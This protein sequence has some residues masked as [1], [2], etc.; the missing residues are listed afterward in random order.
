MEDILNGR[1][2]AV[3]Q[4]DALSSLQG[5]PD[6]S[7][8][9]CVTSP[10]YFG[11]RWYGTAPVRWPGMA[12]A[13]IAGLPPVDVPEW[14]GELGLEPD[15]MWFVGHLVLIFREIRRVLRKD[16]T[17]WLNLGDSA[18]SHGAGATSKELRWMGDAAASREARTPPDGLKPKNMVGIPWRVA[19]ALQADG[20]HLRCDIIYAKT[21]PMPESVR[22]R[23]T[24]SHEYVYLLSKSPRYHYDAVAIAEP[25]RTGDNG[26]FFDR[27][28]T[29]ARH[30]N[31]G[32]DRRLKVPAGWNQGPGRHD[33]ID[34]RYPSP[35]GPGNWGVKPVGLPGENPGRGISSNVGGGALTRN[36]RSVWSVS[37]APFPDAHFATFPPALVEPMILAGTSEAGVCSRCGAPFVRAVKRVRTLDGLPVKIA[38]MRNTDKASPSSAQGVAHNRTESHTVDL[39]FRPGCK[40]GADP[41]P[42][43]VLDPFCGSGTTGVVARRLGRRF[44]GI[45]L[46]PEYAKMARHRI[47]EDAPLFNRQ[48]GPGRVAE[49][50]QKGSERPDA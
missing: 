16:G 17:L 27:G 1:S 18:S 34:G 33:T 50:I 25:A 10:P 42:A 12:Y 28:K 19:F 14:E 20:W 15:P 36:K 47:S 8:H 39:G 40:C 45:E 26:S 21:N 3:L 31:Q 29:G 32:A 7:I 4:G 5:L 48:Y 38:P 6:E 37:S 24:R 41:V 22:D 49:S 44:V 30:D 46:K 35:R 2:W 23:P 43:I 13:P 9:C 11:L